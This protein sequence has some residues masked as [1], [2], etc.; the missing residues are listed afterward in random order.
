[1]YE[2]LKADFEKSNFL[3]KYKVIEL[4]RITLDENNII[5]GCNYTVDIDSG[6]LREET[7]NNTRSCDQSTNVSVSINCCQKCFPLIHIYPY[8]EN[9]SLRN[10]E[11]AIAAF[12][13]DLR[14]YR[15]ASPHGFRKFGR[16]ERVENIFFREPGAAQLQHSIADFF[17]VRSMVGIG[18][19]HKP[20]A[21]GFGQAQMLV[22][23]VQ[24]IRI[25]IVLHGNARL[26]GSGKDLV[27]IKAVAFTAQ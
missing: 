21:F 26:G 25:S 1:M 13:G 2:K 12:S 10:M 22:A 23:Q 14:Q 9:Y 24:T 3:S 20:H 18:V 15:A 4:N 8:S 6:Y 16:G 5:Q 11:V 7:D 27:A 19:D 17:Q